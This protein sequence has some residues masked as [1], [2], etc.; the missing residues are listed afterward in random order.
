MSTK[1]QRLYDAV[2]AAPDDDGPRHAYAEYIRPYDAARA[3]LITLQLA[4][5]ATQRTTRYRDGLPTTRERRL[6]QDD[7]EQWSRTLLRYARRVEY[8]RG[9]VGSI[10]I[11]PFLFLEYG[12]WLFA[13]APLCD[14]RFVMA[15]S[16][17]FPMADLINSPLLERLT[18]VSITHCLDDGSV[19]RLAGSPYL[20][21]CMWLDLSHNILSFAA[22]DAIARSPSLRQ[23]L[24]LVRDTTGDR[25]SHYFPGQRLVATDRLN[26]WDGVI[27]EWGPVSP[28]G[29]QLERELGYIPW[30][31]RDNFCKPYDARWFV[32][33]GVLPVKPVG[34]PVE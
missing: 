31:H 5:S 3:E 10:S 14:V 6:L 24:F 4:R 15:E 32:E 22:F 11:D 28:E 9:F 23:L 34:S 33:H 8:H 29:Q 25:L 19:I 2:L 30:L 16:V 26:R 1:E 13:N 7:S 21:N 17:P 20:K 12:E 18:G 27:T